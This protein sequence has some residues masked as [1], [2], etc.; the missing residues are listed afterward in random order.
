MELSMSQLITCTFMGHSSL[1]TWNICKWD[2]NTLNGIHQTRVNSCTWW[3]NWFLE[4]EVTW[5]ICGLS[6]SF[7]PSDEELIN[8]KPFPSLCALQ[9]VA[10]ILLNLFSFFN[11]QNVSGQQGYIITLQCDFFSLI[12]LMNKNNVKT[13][14]QYI[15]SN[16]GFALLHY[17]S[18]GDS[19]KKII[20]WLWVCEELCFPWCPHMSKYH[21]ESLTT[22]WSFECIS[23]WG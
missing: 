8:K 20:L 23:L 21:L 14:L 15:S 17:S 3:W 7:L 11:G 19:W 9:K 10:H 13:M 18:R 5:V 1:A 16:F 2:K 12:K 4:K 6:L 22:V